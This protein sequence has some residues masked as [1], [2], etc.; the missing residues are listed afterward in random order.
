MCFSYHDYS[1]RSLA[2][3][4]ESQLIHLPNLP[5]PLGR[6]GDINVFV[7]TQ[8]AAVVLC[9]DLRLAV[10]LCRAVWCCVW[11]LL[12]TAF[13]LLRGIKTLALRVER[14]SA[15]AAALAA[16]LEQHPSVSITVA[17]PQGRSHLAGLFSLQL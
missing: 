14:Q 12:S 6:N 11:S 13:L 5:L 2:L 15:T 17:A 8:R 3:F 4:D 7:S 10:V 16:A 1:S 9:G